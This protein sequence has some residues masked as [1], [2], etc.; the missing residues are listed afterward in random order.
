MFDIVAWWLQIRRDRDKA[1]SVVR[2]VRPWCELICLLHLFCLGADQQLNAVELQTTNLTAIIEGFR[3]TDYDTR[4]RMAQALYKLEP[5]G[6]ETIPVLVAALSRETRELRTHFRPGAAD[7]IRALCG[8]LERRG[9]EARDAIPALLELG[10]SDSD[11]ISP[12]AIAALGTVGTESKETVKVLGTMLL[13]DRD[14]GRRSSAA[15]ALGR[16]GNKTV[17]PYLLKA[18]DDKGLNVDWSVRSALGGFKLA[19]LAEFVPVKA[20]AQVRLEPHYKRLAPEDARLPLFLAD[21]QVTIRLQVNGAEHFASWGRWGDPLLNVTCQVLVPNGE[22]YHLT[23]EETENTPK[24]SACSG[25]DLTLGPNGIDYTDDRPIPAYAW[26]EKRTPRFDAVGV[27][28]IKLIG[29]FRDRE[30]PIS[31]VRFESNEATYTV[32]PKCMGFKALVNTAI[33]RAAQEV[34]VDAKILKGHVKPSGDFRWPGPGSVTDCR[35]VTV[36]IPPSLYPEEK[37]PRRHKGWHYSGMGFYY[38]YSSEGKIL[39]STNAPYY[40]I[41]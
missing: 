39:S 15:A 16:T 13:Q 10:K 5:L 19:T 36:G 24:D 2:A 12:H 41:D 6:K 37:V 23:V 18:L 7:T 34:G 32:D 22:E 25:G 40:W 27:Y 31:E 33:L 38:Q 14:A 30:D 3:S 20:S 9:G 21:Y 1:A 11:W 17:I 29:V 8:A 28:K 26:R 4:Q 35:C